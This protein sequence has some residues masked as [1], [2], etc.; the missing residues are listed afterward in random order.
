MTFKFLCVL[1]RTLLIFIILFIFTLFPTNSYSRTSDLQQRI[2]AISDQLDCVTKN[3]K[4]NQAVTWEDI[5]YTG[6][7]INDDPQENMQII[8]HALDTYEQNR[9][10]SRE[11]RINQDHQTNKIAIENLDANR[12]PPPPYPESYKFQTGT[13]HL[14]FESNDLQERWVSTEIQLS[15]GYRQD[16]LLWNIADTDGSPNI[17]SELDWQNLRIWHFRSDAEITFFNNY[18]IDLKADYGLIWAGDNQD[19]DYLGNNKTFEFSRSN[20]KTKDDDVLDL[21]LGAGLKFFLGEYSELL[22]A[23]DVWLSLLAGYSYHEQNLRITEGFQTIPATGPFDGLNSTYQTEWDG[24]WLGVGI[25]GRRDKF[26]VD[27]GFEYHFADYYAQANWNLRPDFQH[28][29]SF[30]HVAE[31]RGLVLDVEGSYELTKN[32]SVNLL[33]EF[34]KWRAEDGIDRTFFSNGT[35]IETRLNEV[36]WNSVAF[37]LG[38]AYDF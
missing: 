36:D 23:S 30:E 28:P 18:L 9:E 33:L 27:V 22:E 34:Q 6:N 10:P 4:Q 25:S 21:S 37:T 20:N 26:K 12:P 3:L 5:C 17:L 24:P 2:Q 32:W 1:K 38:A 29:K 8:D 7:V 35:I 13:G 16:A 19:S 31:G 15:T 11:R 14:S